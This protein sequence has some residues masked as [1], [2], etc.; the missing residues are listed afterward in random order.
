[1][2]LQYVL[3]KL[4]L[5]KLIPISFLCLCHTTNIMCIDLQIGVMNQFYLGKKYYLKQEKEPNC[6]LYIKD[7]I[8][9][10]S[11]YTNFCN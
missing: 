2:H 6:F 5:L 4:V 9:Q 11:V 8:V 3:F 1:M 10:I 7:R